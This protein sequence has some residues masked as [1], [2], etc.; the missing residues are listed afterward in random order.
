MKSLITII[1]VALLLIAGGWAVHSIDDSNKDIL[2]K[3]LFR[4][5]LAEGEKSL[6]I[7]RYSEARQI[8]DEELKFNPQNV[9]AAWGKRK[10]EVKTTLTGELYKLALEKLLLEK[11]T[12]GHVNLFLGDYFF[13]VRDFDKAKTY[14]ESAIE[15]NPKLAEAHFSLAELYEKRGNLNFARVE[16]LK[17]ITISPEARYQHSLANIYFKRGLFEG[18]VKEFGKN[19]EY[20]LSSI[21][22]SKI[23]W[24][25]GY[26]SQSLN[27]Q[28]QAI[29]YLANARI[30]AKSENQEPWK[31]ELDPEKNLL[32]ETLEEKQSY[33]N[34]CFSATLFLQG[35]AEAAKK[36][37]QKIQE[38]KLAK[39]HQINKLIKINLETLFAGNNE[40]TELVESFKQLYLDTVRQAKK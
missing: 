11:P 19:L 30:M 37:I 23:F 24:R 20:P 25:L 12:D 9:E 1:F 39:Q 7:G 31:M 2:S 3:S 10:A 40:V 33:A 14:F 17:A 13:S 35:N 21:E 18:A 26:L 29:S 27:Y 8:F 34:L 4:Q 38:L 32:L 28:L 22:I 36:E 16:Y 6:N 5:L 15:L